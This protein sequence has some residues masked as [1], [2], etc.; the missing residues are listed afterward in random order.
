MKYNIQINQLALAETKLD[1][2]DSAI[3][4]YLIFYCNSK[5]PIIE[6]ER[7]DYEGEKW[8][9]I[10]LDSILK[11]MPLLRIKEKAAVSRR[12][13]TIEKEGYIRSYRPNNRRQYYILTS[14]VDSLY[15]DKKTVDEYQQSNS[16]E[17][18]ELLTNINSTVDVRQQDNTINDNDKKSVRKEKATKEVLEKCKR[19]TE[20][21]NCAHCT[22]VACTDWDIWNIAM[23]LSIHITEVRRKHKQIMDMINSG[24]FQQRYKKHKTVYL[25]LRNWLNG[26]ISKG[27]IQQ[28]NEVEIMDNESERPDLV[29]RRKKLR[30]FA[31]KEGIL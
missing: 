20:C 21:G 14:K 12:L 11:D 16:S 17:A 19:G 26:D 8:T 9:W 29:D 27:F 2:V 3:L 25:T 13:T 24:E 23:D 4:D 5:N 15:V 22:L 7:I 10:K 31:M 30:E 28:A 6:K 1:I 18:N